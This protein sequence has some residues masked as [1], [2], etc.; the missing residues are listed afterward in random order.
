MKRVFVTG[1]TGLVGSSFCTELLRK[2][3]DIHIT[4]LVRSGPNGLNAQKKASIAIEEQCKF[5][6]FP[7]S[8]KS[9]I[10]RIQVIEG[11]ITDHQML[12]NIEQTTGS[13]YIF[14]CAADVNFG[15]DIDKKTYNAN[16]NGTKNLLAFAKKTGVKEFHHVSTAYVAGK[17]IGDTPEDGLVAK[18]FNNSYE[19]SKFDSEKL[20]REFG[21][22]FSIYRPSIVVGRL[23]DGQIR[24]P[25]A[26]YRLLEFIGKLRK[27]RCGKLGFKPDEWFDMQI[28]LV[29]QQSDRV[30]F[31]PI[32]YVQKT[33]TELFLFPAENKTY[34]ITGTSPVSTAGIEKAVSNALKLKG[35]ILIEE[36]VTDLTMEEKMVHRFVG[37]F[38]PYFSSEMIFDVK[39]V[40]EKLGD[41]SLSWHVRDEELATVIGSFYQDF[42]NKIL[43]DSKVSI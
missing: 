22:P 10:D 14:H 15:K 12:D 13:G 30:Y 38:L 32:D 9:I 42:N 33:I 26:F 34:H 37:D 43:P 2:E 8:T 20:V 3:K 16:F 23:S 35:E 39:N 41:D 19:K 18:E 27:H 5:D 4:A 25:L 1:I 40:R 29:V 21:I 7:N 36:D 28:R 31:V 11:D 24:K 6:G 17:H